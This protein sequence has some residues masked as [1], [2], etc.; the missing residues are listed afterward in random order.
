VPPLWQYFL[1]L[2]KQSSPSLPPKGM[3][4]EPRCL[5][6][7]KSAVSWGTPRRSMTTLV[8]LRRADEMV[9]EG[10]GPVVAVLVASRNGGGWF[11]F[12]I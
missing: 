11:S 2:L 4:P 8:G 3:D 12:P 5:R 10:H 7:C 1:R 6:T 9:G